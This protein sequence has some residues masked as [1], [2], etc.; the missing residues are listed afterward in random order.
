M[1]GAIFGFVVFIFAQIMMAIMGMILP[2]PPMEGGM[3]LMMV[4]SIIG[5][6]IFGIIVALFVKAQR[7][8]SL[9]IFTARQ[10]TATRLR[11]STYNHVQVD[12]FPFLQYSAKQKH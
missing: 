9:I 4:G 12:N 7:S 8:T 1:K 6:I 2:M 10:V 5:H 3:V 11:Y